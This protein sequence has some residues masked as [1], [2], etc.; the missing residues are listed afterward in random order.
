[1]RGRGGKAPVE[2]ISRA[3]DSVGVLYGAHSNLCARPF[4]TM[5][6]KRSGASAS[7]S[8]A[9]VNTSDGSSSSQTW[10]RWHAQRLLRSTRRPW[11]NDRHLPMQ[12]GTWF[13][14]PAASCE[15]ADPR[16]AFGLHKRQP[17]SRRHPP[18]LGEARHMTGPCCHV[19][20]NKLAFNVIN[21]QYKVPYVVW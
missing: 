20:V 16:G 19:K 3:S 13:D 8:C 15:L 14:F 12:N 1:M 11:A 6:T 4:F 2:E 21:D 18:G 17:P 9:P 5:A 7:R 10:R